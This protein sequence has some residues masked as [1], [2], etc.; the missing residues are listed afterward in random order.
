MITNEIEFLSDEK[1]NTRLNEL[2]TSAKYHIIIVSPWLDPEL[3]IMDKLLSASKKINNVEIITLRPEKEIYQE[4]IDKLSKNG[5]QVFLKENLHAKMFIFDS[6]DLIVGST[7]LK[8]TSLVRNSE[9]ALYTNNRE[10][11]NKAC[12]YIDELKDS[13]EKIITD[14]IAPKITKPDSEEK[15][16]CIQCGTI[17]EFDVE[18]PLCKDC[19]KENRHKYKW[20]EVCHKCGK[21]VEVNVARPLCDDCYYA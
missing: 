12:E 4:A 6:R 18:K 17:K 15:G 14:E 21:K 11:V 9:A 8:I 1:I 19:W 7:N 16:Y 2:I 13:G 3:H 20:R 5:A 10:V